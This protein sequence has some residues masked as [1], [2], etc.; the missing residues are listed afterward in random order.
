MNSPEVG[1]G[2]KGQ[3]W[4]ELPSKEVEGCTDVGN[5]ALKCPGFGLNSFLGGS[6]PEFTGQD[7]ARDLR[8][9][10]ELMPHQGSLAAVR[11]HGKKNLCFN[12]QQSSQ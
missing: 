12:N 10:A 2:R 8:G 6:K 1:F 7:E 5:T 9:S 3:I 4:A 11:P